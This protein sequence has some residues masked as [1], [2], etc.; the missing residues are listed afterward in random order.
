MKV[1]KKEIQYKKV[2]YQRNVDLGIE[3]ECHECTSHFC[4]SKKYPS[5]YRN[6]RKW[7]MS[8][9][10]YFQATGEDPEV[11]MHLCDNPK[12]ININHLKAGT[13]SDNM[14]DAAR[15][16]RINSGEFKPQSKLTKIEILAIRN[17]ASSGESHR[18]LAKKYGVGKTTIGDVVLRKKWGS[19]V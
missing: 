9:W 15:K 13:Q 14:K 5:I 1:N 11:V 18:K 19:V 4:D 2:L 16:G 12:C 6:N 17:E 10:V 7:V 8:R 3:A